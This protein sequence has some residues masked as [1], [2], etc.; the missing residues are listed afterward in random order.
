MEPHPH[1]CALIDSLKDELAVAQERITHLEQMIT[2]QD[3]LLE[4]QSLKLHF[5]KNWLMR[6]YAET[7]NQL[8][9]KA[10]KEL[11]KPQKEME[12]IK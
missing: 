7:K 8:F 9:M 6:A 10:I 3:L 12:E 4:S 1:D 11:D 5:A 2:A